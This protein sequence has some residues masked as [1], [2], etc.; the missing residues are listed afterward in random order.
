MSNPW[1]RSRSTLVDGIQI[2]R[3][4]HNQCHRPPLLFPNLSPKPRQQLHSTDARSHP[5]SGTAYAPGPGKTAEKQALAA[6]QSKARPSR[7]RLHATTSKCHREQALQSRTR[8]ARPL[9]VTTECRQAKKPLAQLFFPTIKT[10]EHKKEPMKIHNK[11]S[12]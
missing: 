8:A 10:K 9:V 1:F 5:R 4:Q 11:K 7:K 3:S 6:L 2:K 12:R